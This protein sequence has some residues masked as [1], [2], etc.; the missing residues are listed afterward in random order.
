MVMET[1][2]HP[3]TLLPFFRSPVP[4]PQPTT[5]STQNEFDQDKP[6]WREAQP[7]QTAA[8]LVTKLMLQFRIQ[9]FFGIPHLAQGV[10]FGN[11]GDSSDRAGHEPPP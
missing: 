1:D 8:W 2:T 4:T 9:C 11:P 3:V 6:Q 5:E 7:S 10:A